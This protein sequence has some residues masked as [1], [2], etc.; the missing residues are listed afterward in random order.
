MD[1]REPPQL[2]HRGG[3]RRPSA[4]LL[5]RILT[6]ATGA[7]VLIGAIAVSIV[8]FAVALVVILGV[9]IYLWW[10]TRKVRKHLREQ[11]SAQTQGQPPPPRYEDDNVIEGEVVRKEESN[12]PR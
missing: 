5:A 11:M 9:G 1:Y 2:G 12:N 6:V 3:S 7:L 8:V 4:G 10:N